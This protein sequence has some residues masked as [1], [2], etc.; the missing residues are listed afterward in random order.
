MLELAFEKKM[1]YTTPVMEELKDAV[2]FKPAGDSS[3]RKLSIYF[4][5]ST[6]IF[7]IA[8]GFLLLVN[9]APFAGGEEFQNLRLLLGGMLFLYGLLRLGFIIIK[10]RR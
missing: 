8:Y 9:I 3:L 2:H 5:I 10:A 7:M 6:A 4:Q 1:Y